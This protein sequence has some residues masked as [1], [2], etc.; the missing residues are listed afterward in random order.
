VSK[1]T[2][3]AQPLGDSEAEQAIVRLVVAWRAGGCEVAQIVAML[4]ADRILHPRTGRPVDSSTI[5][6]VLA[7]ARAESRSRRA[8]SELPI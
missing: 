3:P 8:Q 7:R 4:K 5:C 2:K 6:S 1:S